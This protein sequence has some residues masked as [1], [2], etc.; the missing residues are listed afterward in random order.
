MPNRVAHFPALTRF[1]REVTKSLTALRTEITQ[2]EQELAT[3]K[4]EA[5]Q[6]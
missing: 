2:R 5:A 3:L 1:Q 4:E 6:W